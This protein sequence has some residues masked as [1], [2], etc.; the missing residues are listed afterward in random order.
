[1]KADARAAAL[2]GKWASVWVDLM[3]LTWAAMWEGKKVDSS[4]LARAVMKVE[5]MDLLLAVQMDS[6]KAAQTADL[7]ADLTD[8]KMVEQ[9]A[10][11]TAGSM[12][13]QW[14]GMM[15]NSKAAKMVEK[16]VGGLDQMTVV[17]SARRTAAM[18]AESMVA[19][20][21][22]QRADKKGKMMAGQMVD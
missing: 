11:W 17:S 8:S 15:D 14:A 1:M 18:M 7:T 4:V 19:T 21:A 5:L 12:V 6:L 2:V 16:K 3:V 10:R 22:D 20:M 9:S 13:V